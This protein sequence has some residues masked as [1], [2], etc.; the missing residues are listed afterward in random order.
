MKKYFH[1]FLLHFS[2]EMF[3]VPE[4]KYDIYLIDLKN[5]TLHIFVLRTS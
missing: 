2:E 5:N 4:K 3:L 1:I